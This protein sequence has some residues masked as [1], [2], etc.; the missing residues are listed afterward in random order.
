MRM[1]PAVVRAA[2]RRAARALPRPRGAGR[3]GQRQPAGRARRRREDGGEVAGQLRRPRRRRRPGRRDH[4]QGGR[5]PARRTSTRCCATAGSTAL[6]D[7]VALPL[8]VDD[9]ALRAWDREEVHQVFDGLEFR[10][11]R[12]RLFATLSA[13]EPEAEGGFELQGA[14]LAGDEVAAWLSEHAA[15][16]TGVARRR[17]LGPRHR[18]S[19]RGLAL[20]TGDGSSAYIDLAASRRRGTGAR[21]A[22]R[23]ARRPRP[24]PRCCT[25][26]RAR[27][28]RSAPPGMPTRGLVG[29]TALV[30]LPVP[31]RPALLR[32]GR[33]RPA[34]PRPRAAR[35]GA[36]LGQLTLDTG[37]AADEAEL[38][39]VRARAVLELSAVLDAE[40]ERRRD[41]AADPTSSC[42]SSTSSPA[43]SAPASPATSSGCGGSRATSPAV[44]EAADEAYAVIDHEI[45]L[46]SP[47]AAAGGALR[48][49]RDAE[50]EADEDR[51]D[52][53]RR[54]AAGPVR[55]D[56]APV[57]AAP[58][59]PPRRQPAAPDRRGPAE[60][61]RDDGRIHT[62]Y[63]QTIAATGRLSSTD[64]N[65]QNIPIRT[66]EG[67]RIREAFVVGPG[68]ECLLTADYSQ[69]E[70]RI[71]A[72]LSEDEGLI[73]A[74]RSGE[75]LHRA[76][77]AAGSSRCRRPRSRPRCARRSRRC[78]TGS[79]T[80]CRRSGCPASSR[81]T[82]TRP[83]G[84][85]TD[86]FD[87][88]G[89]VRDYLRSR[90]R[91]G[92]AAPATPRRSWVGAGT[93]P[94][95]TSDN[96]QR[97]E[98]AERMA[99]NAPI[100]GSAADIIK[101]AMLGVDAEIR[102]RGLA[103]RMLLQVHDELVLE[104]APGER[105]E[106]EQLGPRPDGRRRRARRAARGLGGLRCELARG[107]A[108][109]RPS[110]RTAWTA[111]TAAQRTASPRCDRGRSQTKIAVPG[112]S[113][114]R[115]RAPAAPHRRAPR[116]PLGLDQVGQR[117]AGRD[118]LPHA[119]AEGAVVLGVEGDAV[120]VLLHVGGAVEVGAARDQPPRAGV[121]GEGPAHRVADGEHPPP[122]R[123]QHPGHLAAAPAARRRR[124]AARRRPSTPGRRCRRRAA[125]PRRRPAPAAPGCA[126]RV[127]GA[128][129]CAS[130]AADRSAP[131]TRAPR[132][133]SQRA[134]WAAP[135]ADLQDGA[136][137]HGPEQRRL[138][139]V[140]AL[141]PPD[142]S[143]RRPGRRRAPPGTGRP[144]RPT[145]RGSPGP[146]RGRSAGR[147]RTASRAPVPSVRTASVAVAARG[148]CS[149]ARHLCPMAGRRTDRRAG[150]TARARFDRPC[151]SPE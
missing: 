10:V 69:I 71:M 148:P 41:R 149:Q 24:R 90:R 27:C 103:S 22:G 42:R 55:Q 51:V 50:D 23:L 102:R 48:P 92:P 11:L 140:Q 57:P 19:A 32:P 133:A 62:T 112:S 110:P 88:F 100:Q 4:G 87:R 20:A 61:R 25:T 60:D 97:R 145:S 107:G 95:S 134:H 53:R 84:S 121:V 28:T 120:R 114:P 150:R 29:D 75:D 38:A 65:L 66:E 83:A 146:T 1:T 2:V 54:G 122:A 86:Y 130:I 35:R 98:M 147:R 26:P 135:A 3:G 127:A 141:G 125:G 79:P 15:Q 143:A 63:Q 82:P 33:P 37:D 74:F 91:R 56:G 68:Y 136:P 137:A 111:R 46:G 106:V 17:H 81:S 6:V 67:R 96:R 5:E 115:G 101:V 36:G 138:G 34:P 99:L 105:Q 40:L 43:W 70:M 139:L 132:P 76:V 13:P 21:R 49:A 12:D 109:T 118:D 44:A 124:T 58:A 117:E 47:E 129:E 108:L 72:H 85:W 89:G 128:R 64:P 8:G 59:A 78:P 113:R 151:P 77:G 104:V 126:A 119:V 131:T 93:C 144:R 52:H 18:R 31:A 9:L 73:E 45:N 30:G 16:R 142:G 116:R 7:D 14:R 80:G 94:T 39:M 123:A